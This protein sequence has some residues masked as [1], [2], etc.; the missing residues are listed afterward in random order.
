MRGDARLYVRR[1]H[2][3]YDIMAGLYQMNFSSSRRRKRK[4]VR[5][6]VNKFQGVLFQGLF[7]F[8]GFHGHLLVSEDNVPFQGYA[9]FYILMILDLK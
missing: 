4:K 2:A 3:G 6:D 5:I 1:G 8:Q 7:Q 9:A